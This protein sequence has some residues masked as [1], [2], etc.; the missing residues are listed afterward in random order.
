RALF[1]HIIRDPGG[2]RALLNQTTNKN[3]K[4]LPQYAMEVWEV[5]FAPSS[6]QSTCVAGAEALRSPGAKPVRGFED[7]APAAPLTP[8]PPTPLPKGARGDKRAIP[9]PKGAR[10]DRTTWHLFGIT[11]I[12]ALHNHTLR[13]LG[14]YFDFQVYHL[15]PLV[16]RLQG[17][18]NPDTIAIGIE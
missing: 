7:A 16:G 10:G 9:F 6:Q 4:T 12:S 3:L 18:D 5:L 2:K 15:N 8:S 13:W 11:Q 17:D 14:R 1:Q